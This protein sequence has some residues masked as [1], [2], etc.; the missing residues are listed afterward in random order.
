M[1]KKQINVALIGAGFMG[2]THS[3]AYLKVAKFFDVPVIP[4]MKVMCDVNE[5]A[6]RSMADTWGWQE[7]MTDYRKVVA[8]PDIDMVD[9]LTPNHTHVEI[10]C[11]AA[12]AGKIVSCEKPLAMNVAEAKKAV[13]A[14]KKAGVASFVSFNYRRVPAV[15]L[16]RQLVQEGR[17]GRIYHVRAQYLQDWIMDPEFPMVWRLDKKLCGSGAHGDLNAHIIDLT[18]FITGDEFESVSGLAETFIKQRP[19][20]RMDGKGLAAAGG[21]AKGKRKMGTVTVDDAV[22]F[23][24]KFASG[25]VGSFEATRYAGGRK[26]GIHLEINGSKGS[27]V[28]DFE[29]MNELQF[30]DHTAP[31]HLQGWTNILATQ[32]EHPYAGAW[33]P[34]GHI[35]GYEHG[36]INQLADQLRFIGGQAKDYHPDFTDGLRVQEVLD[37]VMKSAESGKWAKVK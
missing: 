37:A 6:A 33:W 34:A 16:A 19:E 28:F 10:A 29:R 30:H 13:A 31:Q 8:R 3:N 27:L 22:L 24:T 36:F 17:I 4:C 18:R 11:A 12:R 9:I 32:P 23:L 26:N 1:A 35:L 15:S 21:G 14:V 20:G 25:A 7:V 2:R 5:A